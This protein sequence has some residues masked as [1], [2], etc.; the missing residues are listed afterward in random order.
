MDATYYYHHDTERSMTTDARI[1]ERLAQMASDEAI[2]Y[3]PNGDRHREYGSVWHGMDA[4]ASDGRTWKYWLARDG[5]SYKGS[6]GNTEP[7][8]GEQCPN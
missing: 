7:E 6:F 4:T 3:T 2:R 8:D 5:G 1:A